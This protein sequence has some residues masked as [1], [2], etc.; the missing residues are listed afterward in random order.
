MS[1]AWRRRLLI[2]ASAILAVIL[3]GTAKGPA[4]LEGVYYDTALAVRA[5]LQPDASHEAAVL[6]VG[7]DE[8]SLAHP[9]LT[10][11]PRALFAP[12]WAQ[13]LA[14]LRAAGAKVVVFD[15]ILAFSGE[16][17][18]PGYD[19]TFLRALYENR[20][21]VVLGRSQAQLPVRSYSAALDFSPMSLGLSEITPDGDGVFRNIPLML[22][23]DKNVPALAGAALILAGVSH[24]PDKVRLAPRQPVDSLPVLSLLH[25]LACAQSD[26]AALKKAVTGK[27]VF[28]GSVLD[29]EDR[30]LT[31]SRFFF[32]N[33]L[34][35]NDG[36]TREK[37]TPDA[38]NCEP[39]RASQGAA[40]IS[41]VYLH[42]LAADQ[43]LGRGLLSDLNIWL[44][45]LISGIAVAVVVAGALNFRPL[46]AMFAI[47][48]TCL[49]LWSGELAALNAGKYAAMGY[50]S[51]LSLL[52]GG[53]GF[54][55]R[56][57]F[58]ERHRLRMQNAFG[59]YLAPELVRRLSETG[60]MPT[61]D[62]DL[63]E[64]SIMFADLSGFTTLSSRLPAGEVV[65]LTNQY[66]G[67]MA[68]EIEASNGYVDKYIGDAVMAIWGAPIADPDHAQ[69]AVLC[70]MRIAHRIK[71]MHAKAVSQGR[72]GFS[73]KIGVNS[74]PII[75]GNVG[76]KKR[77][78]YTAVGDTV[79][80]AARL[81]SVP[82][83][84]GCMLVIGEQTAALL[85]D[86]FVLR[87]LDRIAVK[88][89]AT[90]LS[91]FEPVSDTIAARNSVT[92]YSQAL[93]LYRNRGF[94]AA[95]S[96]WEKLAE[97]GDRPASVMA[98]RARQLHGDAPPPDWDG[99]WHKM[100]K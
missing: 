93:A 36:K 35:K 32:S 63:R 71:L 7:L 30:K 82:G 40:N 78:N 73:V 53:G 11:R 90:P 80:V 44:A 84:Y 38:Q 55:F 81:E 68:E 3:G 29:E 28:I 89:R 99:V 72:D 14:A 61:L 4:W 66:L 21:H 47:V 13:T 6:V 75:A 50:P 91:I 69:H 98:A 76:A 57:L 19:R 23:D 15:F 85:G 34:S 9:D 2:I 74:G 22:G 62:G 25:M 17:I 56:F 20:N 86:D 26:P 95:A 52:S 51:L 100:A 8:A 77:L 24:L 48:G 37:S 5:F 43:V 92:E 1:A 42:A 70:A 60:E 12:V 41:G 18:A 27:I 33:T 97:S 59:H 46:L 96:L 31:P 58:E 83:D 39:A 79:N 45:A 64:A 88:G 94:E 10:Q 16:K 54:V 65:A 67:L 49:V 87:E